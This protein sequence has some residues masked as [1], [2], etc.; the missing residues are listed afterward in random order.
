MG[1]L[2][3]GLLRLLRRRMTRSTGRD[4][5]L[6]SSLSPAWLPALASGSG[7]AARRRGLGA[8]GLEDRVGLAPA[9]PPRTF[10]REGGQYS[11]IQERLRLD[12]GVAG[13]V[14]Y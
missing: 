8:G 4:S 14:P 11:A 10:S 5:T 6:S 13:A 12:L 2:P 7:A 9:V 1:T 3:G